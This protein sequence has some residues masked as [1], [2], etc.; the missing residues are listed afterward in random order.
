[1]TAAELLHLMKIIE[2]IGRDA[3]RAVLIERRGD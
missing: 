1:M 3:K 2:L